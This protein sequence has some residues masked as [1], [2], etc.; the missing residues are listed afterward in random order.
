MKVSKS[1][2]RFGVPYLHVEHGSV[3]RGQANTHKTAPD[4]RRKALRVG[5]TQ[6]EDSGGVWFKRGMK[7]NI[8]SHRQRS[9]WARN[10]VEMDGHG[11]RWWGSGVGVG[12]TNGD[13]V[14]RLVI[15]HGGRVV[16]LGLKGECEG[17][18]G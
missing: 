2:L 15:R 4:L 12:H 7:M 1:E 16:G 8:H 14:E 6:L 3:P 18:E 11:S 9:R 13:A 17:C 5:R 10:E